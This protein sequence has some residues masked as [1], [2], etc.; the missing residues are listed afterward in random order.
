MRSQGLH[1]PPVGR[2]GIQKT[3]AA[4][5]IRDG[6]RPLLQQLIARRQYQLSPRIME[7]LQGLPR[8]EVN[9]GWIVDVNQWIHKKV[10]NKGGDVGLG[11]GDF[12]LVLKGPASTSG[13]G[14]P[15]LLIIAG[16]IVLLL[17]AGALLLIRVSRGRS[18]NAVP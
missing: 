16:V 18:A 6:G 17:A 15:L 14:S 1:Q 13:S 11:L 12:A 2:N 8:G 4:R 10:V 9:R 3:A 7:T 5:L